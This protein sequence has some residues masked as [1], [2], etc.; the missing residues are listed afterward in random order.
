M[1][2]I[3]DR[4][5]WARQHAV[6]LLAALALAGGLGGALVAPASADDDDDWDDGGYWYDDGVYWYGDDGGYWYGDDD[7]DD[8][9]DVD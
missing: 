3:K 1:E 2:S 5:G 9:W 6:K 4:W 7:G 8:D